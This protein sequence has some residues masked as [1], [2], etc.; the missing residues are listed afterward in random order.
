MQEYPDIAAARKLSAA[1]EIATALRLDPL[2]LARD[3][4]TAGA[5]CREGDWRRIEALFAEHQWPGLSAL[6]RAAGDACCGLP[7]YMIAASTLV[8]VCD[9]REREIVAELLTAFLGVAP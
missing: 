2:D 8:V 9:S 7:V 4:R 3:L 6:G 5:L 1:S